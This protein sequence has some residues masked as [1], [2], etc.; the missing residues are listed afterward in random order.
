MSATEACRPSGRSS[1]RLGRAT[2]ISALLGAA[3]ASVLHSQEPLGHFAA[4]LVTDDFPGAYCV[5]AVDVDGD[6]RQDVVAQGRQVAWFRSPDWQRFP[7][8]TETRGNIFVAAHDL[9]G[10]GLPEIVLA[11]DFSLADSRAGGTLTL[12]E[13]TDDLRQPWRRHV[14]GA[15]PTAHRVYWA[16]LDGEAPPELVVAPI[17]GPGAEA[18]AYDQATVPLVVYSVPE[19][20]HGTWPRRVIDDSLRVVH[21]VA[22]VDL[23][24]DGRDEILTASYE[25]VGLL[26]AT[27]AGGGLEWSR[28]SLAPGYQSEPAPRRGASEVAVGRLGSRRFLATTEPWHGHQVVIY[29]ESETGGW[30]A[31]RVLDDSLVA[32]HALVV[33]DLDEDGRDEIVAG[34]RGEGTSLYAYRAE[35]EAGTRWARQTLDDRG[36][37]AQ[38]CEAVDLDGDGDLD[39]VAAGGST[40]NVKWYENPLR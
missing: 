38:R 27:S 1:E 14:I 35:D 17:L 2:T 26:D 15:E 20:L 8:A 21:A 4:H 33:A 18:P 9:D 13:R 7:L 23:D 3:L 39:L 34:F 24:R 29:G 28:I 12:L 11:S 6:G 19:D 40:H 36:I 30:G 32:S 10:D 5:R 37:A 16:D 25:G 31:R 22:V